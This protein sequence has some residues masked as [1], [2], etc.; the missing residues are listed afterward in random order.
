[1]LGY[2]RSALAAAF[3]VST[4]ATLSGTLCAN[5]PTPL[6]PALTVLAQDNAVSSEDRQVVAKGLETFCRRLS[7]KIP[8][9]SPREN[10]WVNA[11]IEAGRI[12]SLYHSE[13][14]AKRQ[15]KTTLEVCQLRALALLN[16]LPVSGESYLWSLL[17]ESIMDHNLRDHIKNIQTSNSG[18][19]TDEDI[20]SVSLLP[21][22]AQLI[23]I[24]ILTPTILRAHKEK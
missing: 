5:E 22:M 9:L 23:V 14:F 16:N 15:S 17:L 20:A 19:I 21:M 6:G 8:T 3:V 13:E 24:K 10:D 12:L 4:L 1:M 18:N 11:E 7:G 2:R